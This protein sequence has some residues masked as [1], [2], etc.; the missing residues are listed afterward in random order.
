M[1]TQK[2]LTL[3]AATSLITLASGCAVAGPRHHDGD[4]GHHHG[5]ARSHVERARVIRAKPIY[6]TVS[7]PVTTRHCDRGHGHHRGNDLARTV[8]GGLVGGLVGNQFGSGSG[9]RAMTAVGAITGAAIGNNMGRDGHH[10]SNRTHYREER[11][12]VGYRVKY[13]YHGKTFVTRT[14]HHPGDW[15]E[16]RMSV[17]G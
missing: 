2:M 11:Q 17:R 5:H 10:C 12:V 14:R 4:R 9:K 1:N 15:V 6:E 7:V 16:V 8:V 3:I 13:R